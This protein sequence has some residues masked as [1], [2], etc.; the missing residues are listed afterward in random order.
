MS[1]FEEL[2]LNSNLIKA[3]TEMGF[4]NPMPV[5][6][7][8]I[9]FLLGEGENDLIA[10]AQ[11]GTG[12]TAAFG[13]P[14]IQE[15]DGSKSTIQY[16][17]LAPT[18]E[19]CMQ[20]T[21]DLESFSKHSA[22]VKIVA[23]YGGAS[24]ETQ[25]RAIKNGA[26]IICA[27][28][29]RLLDL[30]KRRVVKLGGIRTLV[31]DEADEMLNMGFREDL[32]E[33][34]ETAPKERRT[35][36]FSATMPNEIRKISSNYMVDPKEITIGRKNAGSDDVEHFCYFVHAKD[37]YAA[38]KRLADFYPGVYGIIFCRTKIETQDV[39]DRLIKDGYNADAL[40]GDLSQAQRDAVMNKFRIKHLRLL[41]ATDVAS[42]GLDVSNLSHIINYNLPDELEV[43]TH[44]SGRTGRAGKKGTSIIIANLKEK[45]KIRQI[46]KK[47]NKQFIISEIPGGKE[48]CENQLF[49]FIDKMKN[50]EVEESDIS[51]FLPQVYKKLEDL[52]KEEIIKK[53]VALEFNRF[54]DYYKSSSDLISPK[55]SRR[56]RET[57]DSRETSSADAYTRFFINLGKTD[58]LKP[59]TLIG[60]IND[61]TRSKSID[62]GEIE[63][64]RNFSFFE[65]DNQF[66]DLVLNSFKRKNFKGRD[67]NI[68]VAERKKRTLQKHERGKAQSGKRRHTPRNPRNNNFDR[69]RR[70]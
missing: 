46:E 63:I 15:V 27:T 48:I 37:R 39:A 42:R 2:G 64:L 55:D 34:L 70:G 49:H 21:K 41:V 3:I 68:E 60:M 18:R 8:V 35:L 65:V 69:K 58:D 61:Y 50:V 33:I 62:I 17:I 32:E 24:I 5:Q 57:R 31:L 25:I 9:P 66:S 26:Q 51:S 67:I 11:T 36:L 53:F 43:Y 40:H 7:E 12:K 13:L 16:L 56:T 19:L 23:V 6:K 45:G 1:S 4:E 54:L 30:I 38:L 10:L 52:S 59:T 29:G 20:I 44:R 14:I 28:P 47:L 22:R